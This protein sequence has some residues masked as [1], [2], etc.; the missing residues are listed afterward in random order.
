MS[1]A[2]GR[3][4]DAVVIGAGPNGLVAANLLADAG[5]RVL[6]LEAQATAGGAVRSD[7][8]VHPDFVHDTFSA[9]YPLAL[10]SRAMTGLQLEDH[11]LVWEHAP[12]VLGHPFGD[13]QWAL[14]HR[15]RAR[16][17][18]GLEALH[19]G[20]SHAWLELCRTWDR[21]GPS[22][23]DGLT[24]P[25]PPVR[26]GARLLPAI[27]KAGGLDTVR[28]LATPVASLGRELFGGEAGGLLLAGNA[29]HADFPLS[30]PGSGVFGVLM[31]MLGQTVGFPVP[32]GG[33]Q[34]L[35]DALVARFTSLGGDL[36]L[37][38][39]VTRVVVRD[40]RVTG[41]ETRDGE[42]YDART[43]VADVAAPHLFGGLVDADDLPPRLVRGMR[44]FE[45]DPGTVK[46]DW[47]LSGQ[48]PWTNSPIDVPGTVHIAD[49][50]EEMTQTLAQVS[51]GVV[52]D[53]PFLLT[54]QMTT[55][56]PS[57]SPA[58]TE[59]FWAYTHVPQPGATRGDAG[60]EISGRWDH[61][62]CERFADRMQARIEARAPGF[63]DLVMARRVLGPHDLEAR[64]ANLIGG[65]V[66]GGTSQLHQELVFRPV[67]AMR[68]RA[69]TG[70]TGL[71]LGSASAHPGGG[72]HGA[73][74][75]NAARA[76]LWQHRTRAVPRRRTT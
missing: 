43:V 33:A 47:A 51:S 22:L 41:V 13:G 54:G 3:A 64:N 15:D 50:V 36:V 52:P 26:A 24:T 29:G 45:L 65:A 7:R 38:A 71:F 5:W 55:S 31:T 69:A 44:D 17:A 75:A 42:R 30:S 32:R 57:R 28:R 58:G 1:P 74:G 66:N 62:D 27:V 72:V 34:S 63:G 20:D 6:V 61:D 46:V 19:P 68:G 35:T 73:A 9:F 59:S 11:G 70:V 39:E 67:P 2:A 21:I 10:A 25:F 14:L 48:V 37:D 18:A 60:G 76:A 8:E 53:K 23:I 40:R 12:A 16:T 49:S 56:D 4:Y